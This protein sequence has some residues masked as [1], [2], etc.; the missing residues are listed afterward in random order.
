MAAKR[1]ICP[2]AWAR[3]GTAS[4]GWGPSLFHNPV[5][6]SSNIPENPAP[7]RH[8][9]PGAGVCLECPFAQSSGGAREG[10]TGADVGTCPILPL[11]LLSTL[12]PGEK[13]GPWLL[14]LPPQGPVGLQIL[15]TVLETR[16][17]MG[18]WPNMGVTGAQASASV[19]VLPCVSRGGTKLR[20]SPTSIHHLAGLTGVPPS[21]TQMLL[22]KLTT[23]PL[24]WGL[25]P[26]TRNTFPP[27]PAL[28]GCGSLLPS[29]CGP[30]IKQGA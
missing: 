25:S 5:P 8:A 20:G 9:S 13:A 17:G 16:S 6:I 1:S 10:R 11:A 18:I 23:P 19:P 26:W 14:F 21:P 4:P 22:I 27:A 2:E 29:S 15:E 3:L 12:G 28:D 7:P 30:S 24:P